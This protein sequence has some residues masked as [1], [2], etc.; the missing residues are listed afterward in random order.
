MRGKGRRKRKTAHPTVSVDRTTWLENSEE[1]DLSSL[2]R[3]KEERD[4]PDDP[5]LE[6]SKNAEMS[7]GRTTKP[8][9]GGSTSYGKMSS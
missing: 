5:I 7:K 3:E 4:A 8:F 1:P 2:L 6:E 9:P